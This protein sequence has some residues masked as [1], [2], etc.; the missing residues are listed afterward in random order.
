M[1]VNKEEINM[2]GT[3]AKS[4]IIQFGGGWMENIGNAFIDMGSLYVL[5]KA[6]EKKEIFLSSN[7]PSGFLGRIGSMGRLLMANHNKFL[8][9]RRNY[10]DVEYIVFSGS[11]LNEEWWKWYFPNNLYDSDKKIIIHG[12]G[13]HSLKEKEIQNVRKH[14]KKI[15]NFYAFVSRDEDSFEFYEDLAEHSFNGIDCAF[16]ARDYFSNPPHL[17]YREYIALTFDKIKEPELNTEKKIIRPHHSLWSLHKLYR[18]LLTNGIGTELV[19]S[20]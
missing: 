17:D 14:L 18:K 20:L 4:K 1:I 15:E 6:L 5:N 11:L 19:V 3:Q 9:I 10:D 2:S 12:G 8:D 13:G 7:F 16:F